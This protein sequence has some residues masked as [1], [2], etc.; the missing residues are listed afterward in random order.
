MLFG[1]DAMNDFGLK[2]DILFYFHSPLNSL[3]GFLSRSH[4]AVIWKTCSSIQE[5]QI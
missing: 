4:Q 2:I 5:L 1:Y 3:N